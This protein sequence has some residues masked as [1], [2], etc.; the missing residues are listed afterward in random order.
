MSERVPV[1]IYQCSSEKYD[2]NVSSLKN[3][4]MKALAYLMFFFFFFFHTGASNMN[5]AADTY[6]QPEKQ[7]Q[8]W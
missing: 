7:F 3:I 2:R 8:R 4:E 5:R 1:L 6:F